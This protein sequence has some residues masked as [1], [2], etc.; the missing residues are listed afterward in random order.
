MSRY[1]YINS[2]V[3]A[4][5]RPIRADAQGQYLADP[6]HTAGQGAYYLVK[7][8][9]AARLSQGSAR[10]ERVIR[11]IDS[12]GQIMGV[13]ASTGE[14][15][16]SGML[17]IVS[18]QQ[19]AAD[20]EVLLTPSEEVKLEQGNNPITLLVLKNNSLLRNDFVLLEIGGQEFHISAIAGLQGA[21]TRMTNRNDLVDIDFQ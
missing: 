19:S 12:S 14:F 15:C 8:E 2:A 18:Q 4:D 20:I 9:I 7:D 6:A 11:L 1:F 3:G 17:R 5:I 21:Q 10:P 16:S 13:D